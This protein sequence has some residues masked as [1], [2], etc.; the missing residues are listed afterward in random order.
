[1]NNQQ[2]DVYLKEDQRR[3]SAIDRLIRRHGNRG[4]SRT[5]IVASLR[6]Q[7]FKFSNRTF[8]RDIDKLKNLMAPIGY[9]RGL[10]ENGNGCVVWYYKDPA[11]RLSQLKIKDSELFYLL[12]A[13]RILEQYKGLP[14]AKHLKEAFK[15]ITESLDCKTAISSDMSIP[16]T[17]APDHAAPVDPNVW[18][19]VFRATNNGLQLKIT[20]LKGWT[21]SGNEKRSVRTIE[22][23]HIVNLQGTWYLLGTASETDKEIRQY[24]IS[25]IRNPEV[26]AK[27]VQVPPTFDVKTFLDYS[28]GQFIGDPGQIA[29][30]IVRFK[31]TV[32]HLA[33]ERHFCAT[34]QKR[35]LED[36]DLEVSF[37]TSA[38]GPLPFYHIKSWILSWGADIEV[39]AP[40]ELKRIV[41]LEVS[42]MSSRHLSRPSP[43]T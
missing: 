23:Y 25:R 20:Y 11:W 6:T 16:I 24:A 22:P 12:V 1:M 27:K 21:T 38:A 41:A 36:G 32:A 10:D 28:F 15:Q 14:V 7:G 33:L 19:T 42:T 34:E 35:Y 13:N 18:N 3:L 29:R 30:V 5:A 26:V 4:V 31:K 40:E 17:F 43:L 37:V 8:S 9:K 2:E 39:I